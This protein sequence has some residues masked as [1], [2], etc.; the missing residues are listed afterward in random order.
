MSLSRKDNSA[1][2]FSHKIKIMY[3]SNTPIILQSTMIM[4]FMVLSSLLYE[5]FPDN[6]FVNLFGS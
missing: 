6:I 5:R 4:N 3:T 2:G 1:E